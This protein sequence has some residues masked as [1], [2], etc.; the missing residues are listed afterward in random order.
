MVLQRIEPLV[1]STTLM[2]QHL[3]SLRQQRP[4]SASYTVVDQQVV[5][6]KV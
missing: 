1:A 4:N 6:G 2:Q 3:L 5:I